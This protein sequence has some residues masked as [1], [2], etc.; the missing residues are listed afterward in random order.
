MICSVFVSQA[1][2]GTIVSYIIQKH[3]ILKFHPQDYD[4]ATVSQYRPHGVLRG[5]PGPPGPPGPMGIKG[6]PGRD[7]IAGTYGISGPPGHVFMIPVSGGVL[8]LELQ[9]PS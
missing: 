1:T 6:D 9:I 2:Q 8:G 4:A 3:L 7:G 5:Y